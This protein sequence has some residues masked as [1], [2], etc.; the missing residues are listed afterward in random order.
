M[1]L[2]GTLKTCKP[3]L[4]TGYE[5]P[6][7]EALYSVLCATYTCGGCWSNKVICKICDRDT[8]GYVIKHFY[9]NHRSG[10]LK[11]LTSF[12]NF[13]VTVSAYDSKILIYSPD[14]MNHISCFP[15][16]YCGLEYGLLVEKIYSNNDVDLIIRRN[17]VTRKLDDKFG[18]L[19]SLLKEQTY[20][21]MLCDGEYETI[22][23][24][25]VTI[26]HLKKCIVHC[27]K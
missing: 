25:E 15:F 6:Y 11:S 9:D 7:D 21:C 1:Q 20:F 18:D 27:R 26:A 2:C 8:S 22:P 19:M 23:S 4:K 12:D 3:T 13:Y 24:M 5:W 10:G 14:V 17:G 16:S